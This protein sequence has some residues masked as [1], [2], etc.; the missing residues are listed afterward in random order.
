MHH[1]ERAN[2]GDWPTRRFDPAQTTSDEELSDTPQSRGRPSIRMPSCPLRRRCGLCGARFLIKCGVIVGR[3]RSRAG[4]PQPTLRWARLPSWPQ[5][6]TRY[7]LMQLALDTTMVADVCDR[8]STPP[9]AWLKANGGSQMKRLERSEDGSESPANARERRL[10]GFLSTERR[11][12][13]SGHF[14]L[15]P[16]R[17]P[18]AGAR[19]V[20]HL[21][22][23]LTGTEIAPA[24]HRGLQGKHRELNAGAVSHCLLCSAAPAATS[25][26]DPTRTTSGVWRLPFAQG[27]GPS[28]QLA[29]SDVRA[30]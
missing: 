30:L 14:A 20:C 8:S 13:R 15:R 27:R 23:V 11:E 4:L 26:T 1:S 19:R 7:G 12:A 21:T 25:A 10:H 29:S 16:L 3:S 28:L 6:G 5:L 17:A 18:C 22:R 24:P 2:G 9:S